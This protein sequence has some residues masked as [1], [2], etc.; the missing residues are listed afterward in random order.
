LEKE[1]YF[2]EWESILHSSKSVQKKIAELK[3]ETQIA[4][5]IDY[6]KKIEDYFQ[7]V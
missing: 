5:K 4:S 1:D 3:T 7:S 6:R 2:I